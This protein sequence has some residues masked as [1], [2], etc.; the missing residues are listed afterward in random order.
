MPRFANV[1][2]GPLTNFFYAGCY[3]AGAVPAI[4][5]ISSLL[6]FTQTLVYG[7]VAIMHMMGYFD[8]ANIQAAVH[9]IEAHC[10]VT[11]CTAVVITIDVLD[12]NVSSMVFFSSVAVTLR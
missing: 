6:P 12:V 4:I 7:H 8:V 3:R 10:F 5:G 9:P 2:P 1:F 11:L